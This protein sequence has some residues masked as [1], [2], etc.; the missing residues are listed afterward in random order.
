VNGE[1]ENYSITL[2]HKANPS[3][4]LISVDSP[5]ARSLMGK[6]AGDKSE[7]TTPSGIRIVT[8][9]QVKNAS[10]GTGDDDLTTRL[11]ELGLVRLSEEYWLNAPID[12]T[13]LSYI[14]RFEHALGRTAE[15]AEIPEITVLDTSKS[16]RYYRGRWC[17]PTHLSGRYIGRRPQSYGNDIW[18]FFEIERGIVKRFLD[19]PLAYSTGLRGCDEAWR[20]QAALDAHSGKPQQY[21]L[22][23]ITEGVRSI[24]IFSPIPGW[25]ERRWN[26][27]GQQRD[28]KG[29]LMSFQFNDQD[30]KQELDFL[31]RKLWWTEWTD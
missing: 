14:S 10:S 16:V 1:V 19:L 6:I 21:R 7:I 25:I 30:I 5:I 31:R 3:A 2:P 28:K 12:E 15:C 22:S 8:I 24:D 23:T 27:L 20:L 17:P 13:A 9:M 26:L 29:C 11:A 4:G 18:C